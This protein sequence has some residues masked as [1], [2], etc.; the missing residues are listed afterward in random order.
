MAAPNLQAENSNISAADRNKSLLMFRIEILH[1]E[2]LIHKRH[3]VFQN[4][5]EN[6][7]DVTDPSKGPQGLPGLDGLRA[8]GVMYLNVMT[9]H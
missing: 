5:Y 9:I 1:K 8:G 6:D 4:Y 3:N 2:L 7:L